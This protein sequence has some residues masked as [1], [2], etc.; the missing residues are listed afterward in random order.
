V[1]FLL[2]LLGFL[3]K[4]NS[5]I[6]APPLSSLARRVMNVWGCGLLWTQKMDMQ[7]WPKC[8]S[9]RPRQSKIRIE[10]VNATKLEPAPAKLTARTLPRPNVLV[11]L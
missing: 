3:I 8:L 1:A 9:V 7:C 4:Q 6:S 5:S 10:P 11:Q 2:N